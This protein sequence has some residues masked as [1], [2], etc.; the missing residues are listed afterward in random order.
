MKDLAQFRRGAFIVQ[1]RPRARAHAGLG[2]HCSHRS[3]RTTSTGSPTSTRPA[4]PPGPPTALFIVTQIPMLVVFVGI[5]H[6]I[7]NHTPRLA[8][9]RTVLGVLATFGEAVMGG[10]RTG[11][12][13]D[14]LGPRATARSS[15]A[16]GRTW[17][18]RR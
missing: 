14:G 8:D 3:W 1:S 12:P 13:D 18:P 2:R 11:L 15:P 4:P 7:R 6:L 10:D 17:S 5:A 16:S 9:R